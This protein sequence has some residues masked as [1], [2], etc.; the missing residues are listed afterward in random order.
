MVSDG[1]GLNGCSANE[2]VGAIHDRMPAIIPIEQH[3]RWAGT[4]PDPRDLLQPFPA[5]QMKLIR[6]KR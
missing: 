2:L 6:A 3:A 1:F 5:D 4:E